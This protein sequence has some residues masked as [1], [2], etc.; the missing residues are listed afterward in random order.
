MTRALQRTTLCLR[1]ARGRVGVWRGARS[2]VV[3]LPGGRSIN[4]PVG[5]GRGGKGGGRGDTIDAEIIR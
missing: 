1:A 4:V 5:G 2:A 3:M